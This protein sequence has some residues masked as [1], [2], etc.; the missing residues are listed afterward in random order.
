MTLWQS[1]WFLIAASH[2]LLV[3]PG[4]VKHIAVLIVRME[5]A[6]N[7]HTAE[8]MLR[9]LVYTVRQGFETFFF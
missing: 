9:V 1:S 2:K 8:L 5:A 3:L 7:K 4:D 6:H